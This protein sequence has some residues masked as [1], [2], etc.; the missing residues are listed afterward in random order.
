M[1]LVSAPWMK[2]YFCVAGHVQGAEP[3]AAVG[4][5][6]PADLRVRVIDHCEFVTSLNIS[7]TAA[8]DGPIQS[9][10]CLIL[11]SLGADPSFNVI[12]TV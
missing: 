10:V 12:S 7:V 8:N 2:G 3:I 1:C 6:D 5:R 4:Q 9:Q 11:V